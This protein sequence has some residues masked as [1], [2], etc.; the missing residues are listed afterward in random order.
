MVVATNN[1][2]AWLA[3]QAGISVF[4]TGESGSGKSQICEQFLLAL[5][6]VPHIFC[7]SH[8]QQED[9]CGLP[10]VDRKTNRQIVAYQDWMHDLT[11]RG[12]GL[13]VDELTCSTSRMRPSLLRIFQEGIIGHGESQIRFA[14]DCIR[15]ALA[16]PPDMAPNGT[17]LEPSLCN[18]MYH[19]TWVTPYDSWRK[20]M[21]AGGNWEAANDFPIVGD[22][23]GHKQQWYSLVVAVLD[24]HPD[25]RKFQGK[26]D[27][28]V[29]GYESLRQWHRL[30][31]AL[32]CAS[33][34]R[35][36]GDVYAQL[37]VGMIGSEGADALMEARAKSLLYDP[38]AVVDGKEAVRYDDRLDRLWFLP[39]GILDTLEDDHDDDRV[40]RGYDVLIEM[41]ERGL[42]DA[43]GP[44]IGVIRSKWDCMSDEQR[45]RY[46]ELAQSL[47]SVV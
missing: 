33:Q 47:T 44:V 12:R 17:P 16:N 27:D 4:I 2:A 34:V 14:D 23:S 13:V 10:D 9:I 22:W 8:S 43:V 18:R 35:A 21:L 31:D 7:P 46:G 41:G 5:G 19:H 40:R 15:I 1:D 42:L 3:A 24:R 29:A 36:D 25:L 45:A 30:C 32:A 28:E 37:A 38:A 11:N 26:F 6:R 39:A 20:G